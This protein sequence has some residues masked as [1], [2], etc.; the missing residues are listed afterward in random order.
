MQ[1]WEN[2]S[3]D[4]DI[5]IRGFGR[6]VEE[7]FEMSGIALSSV[8]TSPEKISLQATLHIHCENPD[9]ELLFYDWINALVFEMDTKKMLFGKFKVHLF[10]HSLDAEV[11]GEVVNTLKHDPAVDIKGATMTEL[12][13]KQVNGEWIVQCV[14]DV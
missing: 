11:S 7:A 5:G 12:K 6:T 10:N 3:H 4:A 14:V 1:H 8:V 2:F 9:L 13:V